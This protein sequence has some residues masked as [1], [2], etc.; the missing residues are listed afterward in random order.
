[1]RIHDKFLFLH[2]PKTGGWT[3]R[4]ILQTANLG[5]LPTGLYQH[6]SISQVA[7]ILPGELP[8]SFATIREPCAWYR[9]YLHYNC[10]EDSTPKPGLRPLFGAGPLDMKTALHTMLFSKKGVVPLFGMD[11]PS[12][13]LLHHLDIGPYTWMLRTLLHRDGAASMGTG[14]VRDLFNVDLLL[15]TDAIRLELG[16]I[17][18]DLGLDISSALA[19]TPD[20]N[21]NL[22]LTTESRDILAYGKTLE[23]AFDDEMREW[24]Y[25]KERHIVELMGYTGPGK[26]SS[27]EKRALQ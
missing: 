17:M 13:R 27:F 9:S 19:T 12:E 4:R 3:V 18:A 6:A 20:D 14:P 8:F 22:G 25:Q 16:G 2:P 23:E 11:I 5:H 24:V 7:A 26:P 15:D 1:M 10:H 21:T